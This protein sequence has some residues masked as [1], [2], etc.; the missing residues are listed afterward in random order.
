MSRCLVSQ[1]AL[2]LKLQRSTALGRIDG[3]RYVWESLPRQFQKGSSCV[4]GDLEEWLGLKEA[5]GAGNEACKSV[6]ASADLR[7]I[8]PDADENL[9]AD[10][11]TRLTRW[12]RNNRT[13]GCSLIAGFYSRLMIN[14]IIRLGLQNSE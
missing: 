9:I 10:S 2:C 11:D 12:P 6:L 7:Q 8:Q 3:K 5:A 1:E 14:Q 4:G 13:L